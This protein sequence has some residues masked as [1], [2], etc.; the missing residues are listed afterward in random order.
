M[1]YPIVAN[2]ET[3]LIPEII[4]PQEIIPDSYL[5][6]IIAELNELPQAW[7]Y[8]VSKL[9]GRLTPEEMI[10]DRPGPGQ[11]K[12]FYV[13]GNYAIATRAALARIGVA[14]DFEVVQTDVNPEGVDCLCRLTLK[15][16]HSGSWATMAAMQWGE[17]R[18][19]TAMA[20]GDT[21]KGATTDGL[22]KCLHEF[23]WAADVYSKPIAK[24]APPDPV[25]LQAQ[26]VEALYNA[27]RSRGLIKSIVD[28]LVAKETGGKTIEQL[29]GKD[30]TAIKRRILKMEEAELAALRVELARSD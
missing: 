24:L 15:F 23:G 19:L 2:K 11:S 16:Y 21:K 22:K 4:T 27:G 8:V 17:C 13:D 29:D 25:D 3:R 28:T 9:L 10:Q 7:V 18:R 30:R 20:L 14:S 6:N 5:T 12:V 1:D 26:A